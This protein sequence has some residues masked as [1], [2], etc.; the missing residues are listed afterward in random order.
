MFETY[1]TDLVVSFS[2]KF[3]TPKGFDINIQYIS[4]VHNCRKVMQIK[5]A[6]SLLTVLLLQLQLFSVHNSNVKKHSHG[7]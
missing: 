7:V 6:R 4:E 3:R 5:S 1:S 2:V